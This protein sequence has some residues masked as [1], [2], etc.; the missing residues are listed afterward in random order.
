MSTRFRFNS[1]A[2][3][4]ILVLAW[5][6]VASASA[7]TVENGSSDNSIIDPARLFERGQ[8]AHAHGQLN[9]AIELYEQAI[10]LQPEFPEAE[11]QRANAL[12]S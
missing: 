4:F 2:L 3:L 9:V 1:V 11:Y 12:F 5:G 6:G 8:D 7:Q 10:R